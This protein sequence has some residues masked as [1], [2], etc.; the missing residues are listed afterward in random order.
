[1]LICGEI[2]FLHIMSSKF[3]HLEFNT[4]FT[5]IC[6]YWRE[7]IGKPRSKSCIEG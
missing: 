3:L 1:M 5:I 2:L 4:E 7:R 6:P